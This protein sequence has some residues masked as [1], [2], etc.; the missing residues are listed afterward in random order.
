MQIWTNSS[1][2]KLKVYDVQLNFNFQQFSSEKKITLKFFSSSPAAG[3]NIIP[4]SDL[5]VDRWPGPAIEFQHQLP[6]GEMTLDEQWVFSWNLGV[7]NQILL[8]L[9]SLLRHVDTT[10]SRGLVVKLYSLY[11][12]FMPLSTTQV[13]CIS[14]LPSKPLGNMA[15]LGTFKGRL[16]WSGRWPA[17]CL[18]VPC[19]NMLKPLGTTWP[20]EIQHQIEFLRRAT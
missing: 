2:Y 15:A 11:S 4:Q 5:D 17:I 8:N 19:W 16:P 9:E 3:V 20:N 18:D 6:G 1:W 14:S 7:L 13:L 10:L 12:S